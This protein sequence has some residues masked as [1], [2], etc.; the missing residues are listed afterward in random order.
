M[1]IFVTMKSLNKKN[2]YLENK[3][4][5]VSNDLMTLRELLTD[6]IKQNLELQKHREIEKPLLP[7]LTIENL[8][9]QAT[10]GKVGFQTSYNENTVT[11]TKA[12][13]TA[14]TAFEDGLFKVFIEEVEQ[15]QLDQPLELKEL[16][17]VVFIRLT[18]LAGRM[19]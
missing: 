3:E 12:I 6:I 16:D 8:E 15:E 2:S 4:I 14:V 1:K 7:F 11:I 17:T 19:W 10:S 5:I 9:A 13:D 18:M